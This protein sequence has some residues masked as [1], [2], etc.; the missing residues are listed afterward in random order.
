V[1]RVREATIKALLSDNPEIRRRGQSYA[2]R[3]GW[4]AAFWG[5]DLERL[6]INERL[7]GEIPT[8][9]VRDW[10][11]LTLR[12]FENAVLNGNREVRRRALQIAKRKGML[13]EAR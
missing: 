13:R 3:R 1:N 2:E 6:L 11:I 9:P 4:M 10:P 5:V 12:H 7:F 8:I